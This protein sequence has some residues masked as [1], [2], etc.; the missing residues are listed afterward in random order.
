[1]FAPVDVPADEAFVAVVVALKRDI[2]SM[3]GGGPNLATLKGAIFK[4]KKC[5]ISGVST[6]LSLRLFTLPQ[7]AGG[8]KELSGLVGKLS[9]D[10]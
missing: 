8:S 2:I 7:T 5:T 1:M 3:L 6:F 4:A 10:Q 9:L